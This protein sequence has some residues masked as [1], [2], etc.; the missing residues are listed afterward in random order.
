MLADLDGLLADAGR[1]D[2]QTHLDSCP[3]CRADSE[4][5]ATLTARLPTEFHGRWDAHDGPSTSVIANIRTQIRRIKMQKRMDFVFNLLAGVAAILVLGFALISI[6]SQFAKTSTANGTQT[7]VPASVPAENGLIA[8]TSE[9]DGNADIFTMHTDGSNQVNLTNHPANDYT[10]VWSPDGKKIFFISERTGNADIFSV[11]PDGS[12]LTQLT[13]NPGYDGFFVLSPDGTRI[14]YLST[15]GNDPNVSRL[16]VMVID[17][18]DKITLTN[19][20]SYIF[21]GWSPDGQGIVYLE[22]SPDGNVQDNE[23]HITNIDRTAHHEW[24][25]NIDA[26]K[27]EDDQHFLAHGWSGVSEPPSWKLYRFDANGDEPIELAASDA[28]IIHMIAQENNDVIF[29]THSSFTSW[30]WWRVSKTGKEF[31]ATWD[32]FA[33]ECQNQQELYYGDNINQMSPDGRYI[34]MTI[35]CNR[36]LQISVLNANATAFN[37]PILTDFDFSKVMGGAGWSLDG[38]YFVMGIGNDQGGLDL[39]QLDIEN[40]LNDPS[41]QLLRITTDGAGKFEIAWQPVP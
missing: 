35:N 16:T 17:S 3:T 18:G 27:W 2:L 38:K 19:P 22:Q 25:I 23:I 28:P 40:L 11:N 9:R 39:Y 30:S 12:A 32:N 5:F 4:S 37:P 33:D 24:K 36:K 1:L 31:L 10:P 14:V 21:Q 7:S 8:F 34:L 15:S 26:I 6:I 20:G 13:D 41:T 29:I